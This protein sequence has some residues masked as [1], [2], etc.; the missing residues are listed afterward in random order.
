MER[1]RRSCTNT[2]MPCIRDT[3]KN[4]IVAIFFADADDP[5]AATLHAAVCTH[6]LNSRGTAPRQGS[7]LEETHADF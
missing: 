3:V 7:L 1:F 6:A 2:D 5:D 4:R